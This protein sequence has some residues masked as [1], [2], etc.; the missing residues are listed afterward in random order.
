MAYPPKTPTRHQRS[1]SEAKT[2]LTPSLVS[3][4]NSI[5]LPTSAKFNPA[6]STNPFLPSSRP[7][8]SKRS[9]AFS[10]GL[11]RASSRPGSPV[12]K[13]TSGAI[14]VSESLEKQASSGV[15]KRGGIESR[16]DVVT[17]DYVPPP[18]PPVRRSR[19]QPAVSSDFSLPDHD[20]E[21]PRSATHATVSSRRVR[22]PTTSLFHSIC[23]L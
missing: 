8:S 11:A 12:K 21:Q 4:L 23:S 7:S 16:M 19:S 20:S 13:S 10:Q 3:N 14:D 17:R 6:D 5:N 22:W 18:Q 2:P 1:R 9:R 15:V